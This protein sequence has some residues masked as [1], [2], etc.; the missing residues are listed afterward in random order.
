M[1]GNRTIIGGRPSEFVFLSR[2]RAKGGGDPATMRVP[3]K[4]VRR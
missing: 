2:K 1:S 3:G 4:F